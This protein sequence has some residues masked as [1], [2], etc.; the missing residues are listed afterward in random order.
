[1]DSAMH[2]MTACA[3]CGQ[4]LRVHD[5][6]S[7]PVSCPRC[8]SGV[9]HRRPPEPP[10]PRVRRRRWPWLLGAGLVVLLGLVCLAAASLPVKPWR[11][12]A[13]NYKTPLMGMGMPNA[14]LPMV[15]AVGGEKKN[16]PEGP[17]RRSPPL[18]VP[19]TADADLRDLAGRAPALKPAGRVAPFIAL[20][21]DPSGPMLTADSEGVLRCYSPYLATLQPRAQARLGCL[22][23]LMALDAKRGRLYAA[24][25]TSNL[26]RFSVLGEREYSVGDLCVYDVSALLRGESPAEELKPLHTVAL[27][28]H[29]TGLHL[30][31]DGAW[32]TYLADSLTGAH[33]GRLDVSSMRDPAENR[34]LVPL[35]GLSGLAEVGDGTLLA[36]SGNLL[37][38]VRIDPWEVTPITSVGTTILAMAGA[39]AGKFFLLERR[40]GVPGVFVLLYDLHSGKVVKRVAAPFSGRYSLRAGSGSRFYLATSAVL[41]GQVLAFDLSESSVVARGAGARDGGRLLRGALHVSPDGRRLLTG[42]GHVFYSPE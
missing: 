39:G 37:F 30:S 8:G 16:N 26:T 17:A 15:G 5:R 40:I 18:H 6:Q 35:S 31:E 36:L 27:D 2:W 41:D 19:D 3:D 1:M 4:S 10:P 22:P 34:R 24:V 21:G 25:A 11:A 12:S 32:V 13:A 14:P 29:L 7:Q 33:L 23:Y 20:A 9:S 38:R 42:N 28:S